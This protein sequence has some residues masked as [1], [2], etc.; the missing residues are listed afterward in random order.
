[1]VSPMPKPSRRAASCCR[2]EVVK[3][4]RGLRRSVSRSTDDTV[5]ADSRMQ[6]AAFSAIV[7]VARPASP[8]SIPSSRHSVAGNGTPSA[9]ASSAWTVQYCRGTKA[10]ISASRPQSSLSATDCT[11]PAE[12]QPGS[13][14]QRI[15]ESP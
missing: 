8:I 3:G 12:R 1:M 2:V 9:A 5:N 4:G 15:G 11:R 14:R 6:L 7:P 10:S 13:L